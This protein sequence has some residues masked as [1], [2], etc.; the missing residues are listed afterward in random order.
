MAEHQRSVEAMLG[1][2]R[3]LIEKFVKQEI[4][5]DEFET[6]YLH[7]FT[8]DNF[9]VQGNEFVLLEKLFFDVDSYVSDPVLRD[10]PDDLSGEQLRGRAA[11]TFSKL[12]G[13]E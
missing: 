12:F 2:Y 3:E 4:S 13:L 1:Q 6:E 8:K 7:T 9:Q 5:A 11:A 10:S